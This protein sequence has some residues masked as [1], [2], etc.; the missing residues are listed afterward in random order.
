MKLRAEWMSGHYGL[1]IHYLP[2]MLYGRDGNRIGDLDRTVEQFDVEAFVTNFVRTGAEWL[3]FTLGQN[4]GLYN[5]PNP[6]ID[7]Y[8]GKGHTPRRNLAKEIASALKSRGKRFIAYLPCE[9]NANI[10]LHR[11]FA[12]NEESGTPQSEFQRRW[13]EVI[14]FWA[15]DFGGLLDGWWF[16]GCYSWEQFRNT[17]MEWNKWYPAARA[18]NSE[19]IVTF[20]HGV[21]SPPLPILLADNGFDYFAGE[22]A[23]LWG[24]LPRLGR[25]LR[26]FEPEESTLPGYPQTLWHLL[27]PID[28]FWWHM[29]AVPGEYRSYRPAVSGGEMERPIYEDTQLFNVMQ[30]FCG[31]GGGVTL[32]VGV[33]AD[34]SIGTET[35]A[36]LLR[37]RE[38]LSSM[39]M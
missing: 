20:N 8:A 32:N 9:L 33:F 7:R 31:R 21:V 39:K 1:M 23:Q 5:A 15:E 38:F 16:D 24:G 11:G 19:A 26:G 22:V 29:A 35:F 25:L 14:E 37:I 13:C 4:S 27:F 30:S 34:G 12:W 3:I 17:F 18:G 28:A 6:V 36:Q 2:P 10:S